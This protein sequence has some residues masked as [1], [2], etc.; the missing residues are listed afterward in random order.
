MAT[1]QG[2]ESDAVSSALSLNLEEATDLLWASIFLFVKW[3]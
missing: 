1:A 3:E 2:L